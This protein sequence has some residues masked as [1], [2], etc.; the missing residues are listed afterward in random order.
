MKIEIYK[1]QGA[2][3][4]VT[5]NSISP[6]LT[7]GRTLFFRHHHYHNSMQRAASPPVRKELSTVHLSSALRGMQEP[8]GKSSLAQ[9]RPSSENRLQSAS[10]RAMLPER[11][12][13]SKTF[14]ESYLQ[15]DDELRV[16]SMKPF[17]QGEVY[18]KKAV[19][20]RLLESC[21]TQLDDHFLERPI[22]VHFE[23][24]KQIEKFEISKSPFSK[25]QIIIKRGSQARTYLEMNFNNKDH[26]LIATTMLD[27]LKTPLSQVNAY[28]DSIDPA[29]GMDILEFLLVTHV[30]E[31]YRQA[32]HGPLNECDISKLML[33]EL[34]K[35]EE[36]EKLDRVLSRTPGSGKL[37]RAFLHLVANGE[38]T[39]SQNNL[40]THL[41]FTNKG[42]TNALR[43]EA[44]N[45]APRSAIQSLMS[46]SSDSGFFD[47]IAELQIGEQST[48][49]V[50]NGST[51]FDLTLVRK[52]EK[53]LSGFIDNLDVDQDAPIDID[54][55]CQKLVNLVT[56]YELSIV[57]HESDLATLKLTK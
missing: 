51:K 22:A 54:T 47:A 37:T 33:K 45:L 27:L 29:L 42:G 56:D 44:L 49:E 18:S 17:S 48:F 38:A 9:V 23:L 24:G 12:Q 7:Q 28:L 32:K 1:K 11:L 3:Q 57:S 8:L 2:L 36:H 4:R 52:S 53:C 34:G 30:A 10:Q 50:T 14:F 19:F 20:H 35:L 6:P 55:W 46:N 43:A 25:E 40:N 26:S 13:L 15:F 31:N 41:I 21:A 39:F 16:L 5:N